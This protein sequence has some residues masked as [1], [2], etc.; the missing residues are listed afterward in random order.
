[1]KND[2]ILHRWIN[3]SISPEEL[4]V[5][6]KRPEYNDL[7]RLYKGTEDLRPPAFDSEAM[8]QNILRS[9]KSVRKPVLR[10]RR[11]FLTGWVPYAAAAIVI[12]LAGWWLWPDNTVQSYLAQKGDQIE[13]ELPDGSSFL[14]NAD[15]ELSYDQ[16]NWNND[17]KLQLQGEAYFDV[18]KGATFTVAT[19]LGNVEVL[20]TTFNVWAR[21]ASFE[22]TCYSGKVAVKAQNNT[23]PIELLPGQAVRFEQDKLVEQ[24]NLTEDQPGWTNGV[25]SFRNVPLSTILSAIERQFNV[26]IDMTQIET[27]NIL[28][29]SFPH[30]DLDTALR[31]VLAPVNIRYQIDGQRIRL[32]SE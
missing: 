16:T 24:W 30:N 20:G 17:R 28:S 27:G 31:I 3:G 8:L 15:S 25:S 22:V 5:F 23:N 32:S 7:V 2:E 10:A 26:Q 19:A 1:M 29:S 18:E 6:Q 14:L 13:A 12:L 9:P 11:S 4:E 21:G